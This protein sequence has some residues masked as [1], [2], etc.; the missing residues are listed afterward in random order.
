MSKAYT[1]RSDSLAG[2]MCAFFQRNPD[3][4]LS[5]DD[6]TDKF[7]AGRNNIH[8]Q[9]GLSVE[10]GLLTRDRNADGDYIYKPGPNIG[11]ADGV[12]MDAVHARRGAAPAFPFGAPQRRRISAPATDLP[13]PLAVAIEDG[14]PLPNAR[15]KR[16]WTPLLK[17][18][19]PNQSA[20]L[21]IAARHTLALAITQAKKDRLGQFTLRSDEQAQTV[22]VWRTA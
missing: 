10:A 5:L 16:D 19:Q 17:R 14:V 15:I 13:D 22:R 12:D 20:Q 3:E 8:T 1:P 6:I 2:R 21:P 18:L 11:K 7:D 9:L 4:E